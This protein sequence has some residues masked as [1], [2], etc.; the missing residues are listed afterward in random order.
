MNHATRQVP[1]RRR[2]R[3]GRSAAVGFVLTG[4]TAAGVLGAHGAPDN[5]VA[6]SAPG[7]GAGSPLI[8]KEIDDIVMGY[9]ES[10]KIPGATVAVTKNGR[11]VL[12]KAYGLADLEDQTPMQ[13]WHRTRIGSVSKVL[14]TIGAL[15]LAEDGALDIDGHLY[16][17]SATP[18]WG[19]DP[20][21]PPAI[22]HSGDG[23]LDDAGEYLAALTE[24][25]RKFGPQ[26]GS[27]QSSFLGPNAPAYLSKGSYQANVTEALDWATDMRVRHLLTH[28]AGLLRSGNGEKAA[29]MLGKDVDDLT[30]PDVHWAMLAG[31]NGIPLTF[32]AETDRAYSN[33]GFGLVG[34]IMAE[35]T[36]TPYVDYMRANVF[37][38]LGLHHVVP[39]DLESELGERDATSYAYN[40]A[41]DPVLPSKKYQEV[42]DTPAISTS[43]GGWVATAQDLVRVMCGIDGV[44][45]HLR[46]LTPE[47][48]ET[49]ATVP[50]PHAKSDQPLG[51]DF[52]S[53]TPAVT[54]SGS[55]PRGGGARITKYLPGGLADAE[56]N[57][58]VATNR[59]GSPPVSLLRNIADVAAD[60]DLPADYDLFPGR[61]RCVT[62]T[63]SWIT[64]R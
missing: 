45:N 40:S 34:Q 55:T 48:A 23:V 18:V 59:R 17:S 12:S 5:F 25:V 10:K 31:A 50:Y 24:G 64:S 35:A 37:Q 3:R 19:S 1:R 4:V 29:A 52:R 20:Q 22:V 9:L 28:T 54:K 21:Q 49:M 43:T 15:Q 53:G 61:Y 14:T 7:T 30:Y 44:N 16:A 11:L 58:A 27:S 56:I 46:L 32:R 63:R 36:G 8:T 6:P 51:W 39:R 41:G 47:S 62:D 42:R 2:T 26:P 33:H 13:P 57:V 38:P 60:A